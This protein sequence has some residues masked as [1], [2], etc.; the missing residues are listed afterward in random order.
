VFASGKTNLGLIH[1]S[2]VSVACLFMQEG[3]LRRTTSFVDDGEILDGIIT[4]SRG[5][6]R[7][8][9]IPNVIS[10]TVTPSDEFT[11][12]PKSKVTR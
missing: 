11:S 12:L 10:V 6:V 7:Q 2:A 9:C 4:R 1:T 8:T 5:E 3:E